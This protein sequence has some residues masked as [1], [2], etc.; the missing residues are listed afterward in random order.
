MHTMAPCFCVGSGGPEFKS[1]PLHGKSSALSYLPRLL[2]WFL[3]VNLVDD[4][5]VV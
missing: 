3:S 2:G 1:S 5:M 4:D